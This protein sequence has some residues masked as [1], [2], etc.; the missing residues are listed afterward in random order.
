MVQVVGPARAFAALVV[1]ATCVAACA[2]IVGDPHGVLPAPADGSAEGQ[3]VIPTDATPAADATDESEAPGVDAPTGCSSGACE[4]STVTGTC[5]KGACDTAGGG[6]TDSAHRCFCNDDSQCTSGHCV[7]VMGEN[8]KTC[9]PSSCTGTG[10]ADGF[11]CELSSC[12]V[13]AF[14]YTP[15]NFNPSSYTPPAMPTTDCN[16]SYS[17]TTHTFNTGGC[18]GQEPIVVENVTQT[19]QTGGAQVVDILVFK[20]LTIASTSTFGLIG[21]NPVIL[22]VYGDAVISGT[23]DASAI[24]ATPGAGGNNCPA[25]SNGVDAGTGSWEPGG[26]GAGQAAAGGAGGSSRGA[27]G[28]GA[29]GIHGVGAAPLIGGCAGGLPFVGSLGYAPTAGAGGGGVQVSVAGILDLSSGA[30]RANGSGGGNGETGKCG[31]LSV[32]Q[33]GTGGAGGGSGGTVLLEGSTVVSGAT[34]AK[35]G[36]GGPGGP[37]PAP[38]NEDGGAGGPGGGTGQAGTAGSTGI[39]SEAG[40]PP[41][42]TWGGFWSGG[43]GGG[44]AG[45]YVETN[46]GGGACPCTANS[47]CSTGSCSNASNQCAGLGPCTGTT[48][49]GTYDAIDCQILTPSPPSGG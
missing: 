27:A 34:A 4:S 47:E 18:K 38:N 36:A 44:G 16:G 29:G 6:C 23:I 22:A 25:G 39:E 3:S 19:G 14:G 32:A 10:A 49:P 41:M 45:G 31:P 5:S 28:E 12:T 1:G 40:A 24:A 46:N 2:L 42:C 17:S 13:T 7:P 48:A 21:A 8:D 37:Q 35:G 33:N 43:G 20:S 30:V 26:G 11:A 9:G 15:S